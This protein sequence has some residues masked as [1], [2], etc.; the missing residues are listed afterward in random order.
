MTTELAARLELTAE[1]IG[2]HRRDLLASPAGLSWCQEYSHVVD[3]LVRY[4]AEVAG[5]DEF[6]VIATGGYGRQELA[7]HSDIDLTVVPIDENSEQCDL[8]IKSFFRLLYQCFSS[9]LKIEVGYAYRLIG[10]APGIDTKTRTGLLDSRHI[11]G[12]PRLAQMLNDALRQTRS[13]G[14]YIL[15]KIDERNAM[16]AKYN[17]TPLVTEPQLKEGAG[18]LRCFQCANWI[19]ESIGDRSALAN[20]AYDFVILVRN[21]LHATT[22][23]G[24]DLLLQTRQN[25]IAQILGLSRA[26]MMAKLTSAGIE[27]HNEYL[28]AIESL[29][30]ARF[31]LAPG[32]LA[33]RGEVR[34]DG[35][36]D[37]GDAAV[38]IATAN[39]LGLRV[40]NVT[41]APQEFHKGPAALFALSAGEL[42]VRSLDR[43]GLLDQILP[44]LTACRTLVPT[45]SVH[46]FTVYEHTLRVVR[47]IDQLVPGT[48]LGDTKDAVTDISALYLAALLHDVGKT[49]E[50]QD[51][52]VLGAQMA[53]ARCESW[54]LDSSLTEVVE[55]LIEHHLTMS[56]FIRIR[57]IDSPAT[58]DEFAQI[59]GDLNRLN[60]LTVLTYADIRSVAEGSWTPA[61][62]FFH[63]QLYAGTAD[64]LQSDPLPASDSGQIRRRLIRQLSNRDQND[65]DLEAFI[66]SLPGYYL[67]STS[68]ETVRLHRHYAIAAGQGQPTVD[69]T[70]RS[71][72]NATEVTVVARDS[73]GL[74][75]RILGTFYAFD[76][77]LTVVKACTARLETPVAIDTFT[78]QFGGRPVP[79][80]TSNEI[81]QTLLDILRDE[82]TVETVLTEKG[83]DPS[84][85][86]RIFTYN[87]T[88]GNPGVLEI[89]A[90][91]GRGMPYRLAR[92]LAEE[93]WNVTAARVGQWGGNAAAAFYLQA[94]DRTELP[95]E[96]IAQAFSDL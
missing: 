68:S 83:K 52:S 1:W 60:L 9:Q 56:K 24:Q 57:D 59:V 12:P 23:R 81:R 62:A 10:D 4:I 71:D 72:I 3:G 17:D 37:A 75:S 93:G 58:I 15:A 45:D 22:G 85:T 54:Q 16:F 49:D 27:L 51:H 48:F 31:S 92:R 18:G 47:E 79:P 61:I 29:N 2:Q 87:Y 35:A 7:P 88:P 30:D 26:A 89:R 11:S 36:V 33:L 53:R 42:T 66:D 82:R 8:A 96:Q 73:A 6:C 34:L 63:R 55:W 50:N 28:S 13:P 19:R 69:F 80:A 25:E 90:P 84:R 40:A 20:D 86:Q 91:R 44:E 64:R 5:P 77:S 46:T 67:A 38:G 94:A 32:V 14:E 74:L 65:S 43:C 78:V 39:R 95:P 76:V 21:L 41:L 70:P